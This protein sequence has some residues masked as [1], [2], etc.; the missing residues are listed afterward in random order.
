MSH[1]GRLVR[2]YCWLPDANGNFVKPSELS[3]EDLPDDFR[4]D[5]DL[6]IALGMDTK[7]I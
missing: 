3:L 1:V 6:A 2:K 4:K 7:Q 5:A